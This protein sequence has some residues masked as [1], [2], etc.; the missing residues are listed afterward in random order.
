MGNDREG[1]PAA[2][3]LRPPGSAGVLSAEPRWAEAG[4]AAEKQRERQR[5]GMGTAGQPPP[6]AASPAAPPCGRRT[7][8]RRARNK[9]PGG[10]GAGGAAR[11]GGGAHGRGWGK[12]W[13]SRSAAPGGV[14]APG[15]LTTQ[16]KGTV[17][18]V[19]ATGDYM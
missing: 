12:L 2:R 7:Q 17:I 18:L 8:L 5:E 13:G 3:I 16:L 15:A 14:W 6:A 1:V 11:A 9:A 19:S 10:G 4:P